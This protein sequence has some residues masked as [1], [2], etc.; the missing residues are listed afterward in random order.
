MLLAGQHKAGDNDTQ[1]AAVPSNHTACGC[2]CDKK[3][4]AANASQ[5]ARIQQNVTPAGASSLAVA[6]A[7]IQPSQQQLV[8]AAEATAAFESTRK[9]AGKCSTI[10]SSQ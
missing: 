10:Q 5:A 1:A 4:P 3:Q 7:D 9:F 2:D 6:S 8:S